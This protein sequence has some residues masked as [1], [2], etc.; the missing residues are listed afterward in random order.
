M[1]VA[2]DR[3]DGMG[4]RSAPYPLY[5]C[6]TDGRHYFRIE[7]SDRFTE[8]QSV[9]NRWLIH[10]VTASAYPE[11]VRIMEMMDGGDG[12]YEELANEE[13]ERMMHLAE[14]DPGGPNVPKG[15]IL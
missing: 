5:R 12:R 8:L 15:T 7:A 14:L 11:L 13:W 2:E 9:G 4:G 1:I 6:T 3:V 10:R